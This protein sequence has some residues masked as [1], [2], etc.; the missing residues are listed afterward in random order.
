MNVV[1]GT[2]VGLVRENN[3]DAMW[4]HNEP[5]GILKNVFA[6]ADGMGGHK[7]GEVASQM[8]IDTIK[9]SLTSNK[10]T[11][12]SILLREAILEANQ[13][14][15]KSSQS[16]EDQ[17]GMG[18][19]AVVVSI[20][21]DILYY[22]YAGDS[23]LYHYVNDTL[24]LLTKDHSLVRQLY[25]SGEI[26]ETE[27]EIHPKRHTLT[28]A[29]GTKENL[30]VDTGKSVFI[31]G[32]SLVLLC[33]DGLTDMLSDEDIKDIL[34]TSDTLQIKLDALI[35]AALAAGGKDNI[36]VILIG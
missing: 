30:I 11:D 26:S 27:M 8:A 35:Q 6:V 17:E 19:T 34:C 25:E 3:E 21:A 24:Y 36:S 15:F 28:R 9:K 4:A 5:I 29:V 1:T 14:I 16:H 7:A 32:E 2:H 22:A 10:E 13:V 12:V 31:P 33:T 23:R 20:D 18:T